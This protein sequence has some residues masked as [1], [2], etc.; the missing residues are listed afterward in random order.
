MRIRRKI[1]AAWELVNPRPY[2]YAGKAKGANVAPWM[3]G[4]TVELAAF[5]LAAVEYAQALLDLVKV[6]DRTPHW[7]L[8]REAIAL[9]YPLR[10][11]KL[12]MAVYLL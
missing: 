7:L 3:Q 9:G 4:P 11:L 10:L 8:I 6:F 12:S 1:A 2:L 5:A